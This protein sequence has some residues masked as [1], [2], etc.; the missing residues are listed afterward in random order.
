MN[1]GTTY[2]G[3]ELPHPVVPGAYRR[4]NYIKILQ[5]WQADNSL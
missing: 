5:G 1:L 3:F 4:A 2:L